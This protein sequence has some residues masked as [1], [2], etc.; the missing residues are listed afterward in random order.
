[1]VLSK[2]AIYYYNYCCHC[3]SYCNYIRTCIWIKRLKRKM[4]LYP[5]WFPTPTPTPSPGPT[6]AP[7]ITPDC[8]GTIEEGPKAGTA[9]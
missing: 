8:S 7:T 4:V 3:N 1:M 6:P 9:R 2:K 5:T